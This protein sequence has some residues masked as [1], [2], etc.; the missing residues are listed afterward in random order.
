MQLL[1][2]Y[3]LTF[4]LNIILTLSNEHKFHV[5]TTNIQYKSEINTLQIITQLFIEDAELL[6]QQTN[7][8][9]RLDPDSKGQFIDSILEFN[10][11]NNLQIYFKDS[12][13]AYDFLGKEYKNDIVL[14]YLEISQLNR[15]KKIRLKNTI[16]FNLFKDQKNIIHFKSQD[17]RKSYLLENKKPEVE[18]DITL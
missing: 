2:A 6:L 12:L 15:L 4:L 1:S 3:F 14:C 13:L 16:F 7:K 10:L 5:T 8:N 11:K 17:I 9:I 18:I